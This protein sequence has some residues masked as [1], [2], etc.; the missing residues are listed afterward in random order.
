MQICERLRH[1]K[2]CRHLTEETVACTKSELELE[3]S[4]LFRKKER[5]RDCGCGG[6]RGKDISFEGASLKGPGISPKN[7]NSG[8]YYYGTVQE[9]MTEPMV[10]VVMNTSLLWQPCS[11]F[12][13]H[14]QARVYSLVTVIQY[15][16]IDY[17]H[18]N[19]MLR[20]YVLCSCGCN[21]ALCCQ[22]SLDPLFLRTTRPHKLNQP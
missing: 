2:P 6:I 12:T 3:Y 15:I 4:F 20:F 22:I 7:P 16:I 21:S 1:N 8:H 18:K 17:F 10:Y 13:H 19:V 14:S 9:C 5:G 11:S